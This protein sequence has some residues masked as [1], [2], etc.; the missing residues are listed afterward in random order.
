MKR[1]SLFFAAAAGLLCLAGAPARA[2]QIAAPGAQWTYSFTS[3]TASVSADPPGHGSVTLTSQSSP[4]DKMGN[5]IPNTTGGSGSDVNGI[6]LRTSTSATDAKPDMIGSGNYT[7]SMKLTDFVSGQSQTFTFSGKMHGTFSVSNS[8]IENSWSGTADPN[9]G[10]VFHASLGNYDYK[11][12]VAKFAGPDIPSATNPGVIQVHVETFTGVGVAQM[13]EP[14]SVVLSCLGLA[15][16]G[17][18]S[19]R[20]RRRTPA[21]LLA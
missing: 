21:S 20:K 19:W 18:A 2:S 14:S 10:A 1:P 7:V 4:V 13:P 16:L 9:T 17:A 11:I 3:S 15:F 12:T 6:S 8:H 5:V